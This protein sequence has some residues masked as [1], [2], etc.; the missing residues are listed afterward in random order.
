MTMRPP[1]SKRNKCHE[2]CCIVF[3]CVDANI[4]YG[5]EKY[6]EMVQKA[7]HNKHQAFEDEVDNM[8]GGPPQLP[9]MAQTGTHLFT[10]EKLHVDFETQGDR[11]IKE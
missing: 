5:E 8:R 7:E 6:D 9:T 1:G 11:F 4:Y 3:C 2:F 10:E